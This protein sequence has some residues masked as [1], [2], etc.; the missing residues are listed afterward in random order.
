MVLVVY[1]FASQTAALQ[2]EWAWQHPE[3]SLDTRD[4]AAK[5]GK[6]A[7]YGVRGKV[8]MLI[9]MLNTSPWKHYPLRI[10]FLK[11]EHAELRAGCP[12]PPC[13]VL[14]SVG[15]LE[16]LE[17]LAGNNDEDDTPCV[18]GITA[19]ASQSQSQSQATGITKGGRGRPSACCI[20]TKAASRT[21]AVCSNCPVRFH[22]GCIAEHFLDEHPP[23][24]YSSLPARGSCPACGIAAPWSDVLATI[25]HAGWAKHKKRAGADDAVTIP[26]AD[27]EVDMELLSVPSSPI[28]PS[29]INKTAVEASGAEKLQL[30]AVATAKPLEA[31]AAAASA[32][33]APWM[34]GAPP[35]WSCREAIAAALQKVGGS[36][37]TQIRRSS[38][39]SLVD[40]AGSGSIS[41][42][43]PENVIDLVSP[44][45]LKDIKNGVDLT[46]G[47][48]GD[49]KDKVNSKTEE[50]IE[51]LSSSDDK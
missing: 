21:W 14:I 3:K 45:P 39:S 5:V 34:D 25:K 44:S 22:V 40:V 31:P 28:K 41:A 4:A 7:R 32:A 27:E 10:R 43:K 26:E 24:D 8:L 16:D 1:G 12:E 36:S 9:E 18:S 6:K 51:L 37:G 42:G 20:C 38:S 15:P 30:D 17:L 11:G 19:A 29:K 50:V 35:N 33:V 46:N 49:G 2:F 47:T 48:F 13:H 23:S